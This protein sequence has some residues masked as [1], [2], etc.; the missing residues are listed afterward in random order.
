MKLACLA[1]LILPSVASAGDLRPF[2][3]VHVGGA[4]IAPT[5]SED[6]D[7]GAAVYA[8]G[9]AGIRLAK[10]EL[11]AFGAYTTKHVDQE[12]P[13]DILYEGGVFEHFRVHMIDVGLRATLHGDHAYGGFGIANESLIERGTDHIDPMSGF[14]T[15]SGPAYDRKHHYFENR[16]LYE[17][18]G[19]Y[20]MTNHLDVFGALTMTGNE[21]E[22]VLSLRAGIGYRF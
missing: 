14:G 15:P 11:S 3:D 21:Y 13:D 17:L 9:E 1:L 6:L 12:M 5:V 19:G 18:R 8:D 4:L 10:L 2:A 20:T 22:T 7:G 16:L